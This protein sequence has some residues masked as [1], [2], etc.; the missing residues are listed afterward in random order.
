MLYVFLMLHKK[1]L[2]CGDETFELLV[3]MY[4]ASENVILNHLGL[5]SL[6]VATLLLGGVCSLFRENCKKSPIST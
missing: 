2:E 4:W 6:P 1:G 5:N 3:S